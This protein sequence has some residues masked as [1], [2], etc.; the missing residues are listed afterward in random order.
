M[1]EAAEIEAKGRPTHLSQPRAAAAAAFSAEKLAHPSSQWV[2]VGKHGS[3]RA[4]MGRN[5]N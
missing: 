3:R 5:E 2:L 4:S 1:P